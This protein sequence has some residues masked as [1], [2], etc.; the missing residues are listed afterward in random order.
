MRRPALSRDQYKDTW[1]RLTSAKELV[2][3]AKTSEE[4]TSKI[5]VGTFER[6]NFVLVLQRTQ[7]TFEAYYFASITSNDVPILRKCHCA[8][9]ERLTVFLHSLQ[10][11]LTS[12]SQEGTA[13]R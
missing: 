5:T 4:L 3:F 12:R 6:L 2:F 13:S 1:S 7:P 9:Q 8:C 11:R 10:L